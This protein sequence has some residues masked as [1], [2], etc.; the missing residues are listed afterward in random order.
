[1]TAENMSG[2]C[3]SSS[4]SSTQIVGCT[5]TQHSQ[6]VEV[7]KPANATKPTT[8]TTPVQFKST[9]ESLHTVDV[10]A[11]TSVGLVQTASAP[12]V[13]MKQPQP[14][15]SYSGQSS[16]KKYKEYFTRLA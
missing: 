8:T 16:Y 15:K 7:L 12:V 1:M 10:P 6:T 14:T 5:L 3:S 13:V 9:D 11:L 4:A 2:A